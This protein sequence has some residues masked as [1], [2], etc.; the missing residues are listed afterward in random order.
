MNKNYRLLSEA[1]PLL[2]EYYKDVDVWD[3]IWE[4]LYQEWVASLKEAGFEILPFEG[5]DD[6]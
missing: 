3:D 6:D 5:P 2:K 4:D 1:L